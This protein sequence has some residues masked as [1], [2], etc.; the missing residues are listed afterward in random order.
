MTGTR[1]LGD[2]LL[3]TLTIL[4]VV[5][6]GS[7]L[8]SFLRRDRR[9]DFFLSYKSDNA[10]EVRRIA[11]RLMARGFK[12][13]FAE[14]EVLLHSYEQFEARIRSGAR[15]CSWAL[16]F[17]TDQYAASRH[18]TNE[19]SWLKQRFAKEPHRMIEV[20]LTDP[21]DARV[22]LALP[23]ASPRVVA[24]LPP[25]SSL[26]HGEDAILLREIGRLTGIDLENVT[27]PSTPETGRDRF[28]ARC[29]P[30]SFDPFPCVVED[31]R[32]DRWDGT[33]IASFAW[34][35]SPGRFAFN[36]RFHK[37]PQAMPGVPV[38]VGHDP[39]DDRKLYTELRNYASWIMGLM[40]FLKERGLHLI[41]LGGRT[42]LALTH[43][44]FSS[45]MRKY[46]IILSAPVPIQVLFTFGNG[47]SYEEFYRHAPLMDRVIESIRIESQPREGL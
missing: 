42:Q 43:S 19:V 40:F 5:G 1:L 7:L 4:L 45:R 47:G 20:A 15:N 34:K 38:T 16:L 12:V 3:I 36:V 18:C 8:T 28:R 11:E 33:D 26:E 37:H 21:S 44:F 23:S 10:N 30:I 29:A 17:T 35:G 46:S 39:L 9:W 13:W 14:Y 25:L 22:S 27:E 24:K 31:W 32:P 6:L 2:A 41:W